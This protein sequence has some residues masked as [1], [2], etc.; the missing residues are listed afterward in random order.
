MDRCSFKTAEISHMW[1]AA[2]GGAG[3]LYISG[4]G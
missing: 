1:I 4:G 2:K 3:I